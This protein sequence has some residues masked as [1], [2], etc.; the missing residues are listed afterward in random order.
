MSVKNIVSLLLPAFLLWIGA[1]LQKQAP[2]DSLPKQRLVLWAWERPEDLSFI[3]PQSTAVAYLANSIFI[4]AQG[5]TSR[6]RLQPLALPTG[7]ERIAVV[8]IESRNLAAAIP[9]LRLSKRLV[10]ECCELVVQQ[11]VKHLQID[12]DAR[13]SERPFY[14][15]FLTR[16]HAALPQGTYLSITALTSWCLGD[17][18]IADLPIDEAVPMAFRMGRDGAAV[19]AFLKNNGSFDL[20]V[21]RGSLGISLD[22]MP[23]LLPKHKRLYVFNPKP[24]TQQDVEAIKK[25]MQL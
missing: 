19:R 17:P 14:R 21:C 3:D 9:G 8:R 23:P 2:T 15:D 11:R 7:S 25:E 6:P 1:S 13:V 22:E 5:I 4:S 10:D 24:W 18:W 16:L 20:P 12:Y